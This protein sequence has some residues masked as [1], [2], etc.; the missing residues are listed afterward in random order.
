M[1]A[2]MICRGELNTTYKYKLK[3][4]F[5]KGL[6]T[7]LFA[8]FILGLGRFTNVEK[9]ALAFEKLVFPAPPKAI[10]YIKN[11]NPT[12]VMFATLIH[13]QLNV[14]D[15]LRAAEK[16]NIPTLGYVASWDN[17]TSKGPFFFKPNKIL[18]WGEIHKDHA[19]QEHGIDRNE[20][21]PVGVPH[22]DAYFDA[23]SGF[24]RER[25][26]AERGLDPTKKT[27]LFVGTTKHKSANEPEILKILSK[28]IDRKGS[29]IANAQI[30]YRPHPRMLHDSSRD[31]KDLPGIFFDD[32]SKKQQ[33]LKEAGYSIHGE[34]IWHTA[35]MLKSIDLV[36]SAF[37]TMIIEAALLG[38]P[39]VIVKFAQGTSMIDEMEGTARYKHLE[40]IKEWRFLEHAESI[41]DCAVKVGK[42]IS[43]DSSVMRSVLI[44]QAT[45]IANNPLGRSS[46]KVIEVIKSYLSKG[47]N[48]E[49]SS[50]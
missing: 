20:V 28:E 39:S 22:F 27:I 10:N 45:Q 21:I 25:F 44:D 26:L 9:V 41:E 4:R 42:L 43:S 37:S 29:P 13:D 1:E 5:S 33:N 15:V 35:R 8:H 14:L 32:Q 49:K 3:D 50:T 46:D 16:F 48:N 23:D 34:D 11:R 30:W 17:L 18:V 47:K 24:S 38:K 40:D 31:I 2:C 19:Q 12:L 6:S 7:R 36:V